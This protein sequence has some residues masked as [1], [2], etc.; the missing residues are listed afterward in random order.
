MIEAGGIYESY[1]SFPSILRD[2]LEPLFLPNEHGGYRYVS[3]QGFAAVKGWQVQK[4]DSST[5]ELVR[6]GNARDARVGAMMFTIAMLDPS[7]FKRLAPRDFLRQ[8]LE[9]SKHAHDWVKRFCSG[10]PDDLRDH[11]LAQTAR[12]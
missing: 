1:T 4:Y 2:S 9:D 11:I 12:P 5:N 10:E 8:V 3:P 6:L 7:K